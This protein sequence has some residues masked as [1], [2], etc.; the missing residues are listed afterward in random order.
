M[1]A[2]VGCCEMGLVGCFWSCA[3]VSFCCGEKGCCFKVLVQVVFRFCCI[4]SLHMDS[5]FLS[6]MVSFG[7]SVRKSFRCGQRIADRFPVCVLPA[8]ILLE[9]EGIV[10]W[11]RMCVVWCLQIGFVGFCRYPRGLCVANNLANFGAVVD[12]CLVLGFQ[13]VYSSRLRI[14]PLLLE[15][16]VLSWT[17][18]PKNFLIASSIWGRRLPLPVEG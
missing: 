3:W 9:D 2:E 10:S 7:E 8:A 5:A 6:L 15:R 13:P 12:L 14:D 17:K 11:D 16:R 4:S 18:P 1:D